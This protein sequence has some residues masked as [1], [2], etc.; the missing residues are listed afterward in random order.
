MI[1]VV[2][3]MEQERDWWG[4]EGEKQGQGTVCECEYVTVLN[5]ELRKVSLVR[6]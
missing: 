4:R 2:E 3:G 1:S 5:K 6:R